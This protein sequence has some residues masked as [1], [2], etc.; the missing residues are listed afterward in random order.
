M[1]KRI[2]F[3]ASVAIM[4]CVLENG[5]SAEENSAKAEISFSSLLKEMTNRDSLARL[6]EAGFTCRQFSSYDRNSVGVEQ[7][8]WFANWDRSQFMGV[9]ENEGRREYVLMDAK[10]PGAIVRFWATWHGP[11]G[12]EFYNGILRVYLDGATEPAI[13]GKIKEI[14]SGGQ[15]AGKPLSNSLSPTTNPKRRAHNLYLP[16]PYA[17]GCKVTYES[18]E[19]DDFGAQKGEALYYQINY[20][21]YAEGTPVESF[22]MEALQ[23]SRWLLA[24]IQSDL[25]CYRRTDRCMLLK[26]NIRGIFQANDSKTVRLSGAGAIRELSFKLEAEDIDQALRSTVLEIEFDGEQAVWC[27]MGDFFGTG[28]QLN[29]Y[30]SWY[31]EVS[32]DGTLACYWIMPFEKSAAV[33]VHNLGESP[34]AVTL[35][36]IRHSGWEWDERSMHFHSSWRNYH[37]AK[38]RGDKSMS[39]DG[40]FDVNYVEIQGR[41]VYVGDTLTVFNGANGWWGEGDEKIY[42]D[43]EK[44]PSHF[45]TGTEDYYGYAWCR[46]EFFEAPFHAQ[47]N[48]G[49]NL[50]G[51]FSVNNRY[52]ALDAIP[53][54]QSLKFDM[55]LWHWKDTRINFAPASFWYARPG[56]SSNVKPAPEEAKRPVAKNLEIV[57]KKVEGALE[58]ESFKI[59]QADGGTTEIQ[60][61]SFSFKWSGNKQLWWKYADINNKLVLE[62]PVKK[63]GTYEIIA[64]LTRANDYGIVKIAV[65]GQ[66]KIETLDLYNSTVIAKEISL[67]KSQLK[68]GANQL[69]VTIIGANPKAVKSG[70]FGVDYLLIKEEK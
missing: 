36:E 62:F 10:G 42:V 31:T 32:Q 66:V 39:G 15:L 70:M 63:A 49:G 7:P 34:V 25:S 13:K 59:L 67:G 50:A 18:P 37:S 54:E 27:P 57:V 26:E 55:E 64:A 61:G 69:E 16:I 65:N 4:I 5:F 17:K 3:F 9:E 60:D 45:G 21:S 8:G 23:K 28:H 11:S 6:P 47:P 20:R 52:R 30:R 40:A 19:M 51:G 24:D 46:P 33:T 1:N 38:T 48:G 2:Q 12:K 43:G 35:G 29:P 58:A 68:K 14:I 44:F 22:S 53:F 41:G 56:A